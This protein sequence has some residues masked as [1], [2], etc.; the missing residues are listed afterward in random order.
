M[1]DFQITNAFLH[2]KS[3]VTESSLHETEPYSAMPIILSHESLWIDSE[4]IPN[5]IPPLMSNSGIDISNHGSFFDTTGSVVSSTIRNG[6]RVSAVKKKVRLELTRGNFD[7]YTSSVEDLRRVVH[8]NYATGYSVVVE[9]NSNGVLSILPS[10]LWEIQ[11][12]AG[13]VMIDKSVQSLI[14]QNIFITAYFYCGRVGID[15]SIK[16]TTTDDIEE[17]VTNKFFTRELLLSHITDLATDNTNNFVISVANSDSV[18]EGVCNKFFNQKNFDSAFHSKSLS[19]LNQSDD[20]RLVN[21]Q[22]MSNLNLSIGGVSEVGF[23]VNI[24]PPNDTNA[25]L[26][27]ERGTAGENILYFENQPI[28]ATEISSMPSIAPQEHDSLGNFTGCFEGPTRGVHTGDVKGNVQGFVSDLSN[29]PIIEAKILGDGEGH[30]VGTVNG[31]LVGKFEGHAKIVTGSI[32]NASHVTIG[33]FDSTASFHVK[34][35]DTHVQIAHTDGS[36]ALIECHAESRLAVSCSVLETNSF[37]CE[38]MDCSQTL[39]VNDLNCNNIRCAGLTNSFYGIFETGRIEDVSEIVGVS[40]SLSLCSNDTTQT[41]Q[42]SCADSFATRSRGSE[43]IFDIISCNSCTFDDLKSNNISVS[44]FHVE[45]LSFDTSLF[46]NNPNIV[47]NTLS[48]S[49]ITSNSLSLGDVRLNNITV[50]GGALISNMFSDYI[51]TDSVTTQVLSLAELHY[52]E[53]FSIDINALSVQVLCVENGEANT[54]SVA[55]IFYN[56]SE[57]STT[58]TT[59]LESFTTNSNNIFSVSL[60]ASSIDC[61][62][63]ESIYMNVQS[64]SALH[65]QTFTLFSDYFNSSHSH[66]LQLSCSHAIAEQI[67]ISHL[68]SI[69]IISQNA[70]SQQLSTQTLFSN[71]IAAN[72]F[73]CH[74]ISV[75]YL[76]ID[77]SSALSI[78]SLFADIQELTSNHLSVNSSDIVS[79]NTETISVSNINSNRIK[80]SHLSTASL[81]TELSL[82]NNLS[83]SNSITALNINTPTIFT[84]QTISDIIVSRQLSVHN[85][86]S[87]I[88][89]LGLLSVSNATMKN[90]FSSI[91]SCSALNCDDVT[92]PRASFDILSVNSIVGVDITLSTG[93]VS[94]E[95]VESL[96]LSV[97]ESIDVAL[98]ALSL[99]D[100]DGLNSLSCAAGNIEMLTS[101]TILVNTQRGQNLSVSEIVVS[102]LSVS[103]LHGIV[104]T[105]ELSVTGLV[106][107]ISTSSVTASDLSCGTLFID[108]I[109]RSVPHV[110]DTT[111]PAVLTTSTVGDFALFAEDT[112][113]SGDMIIQG[114]LYVTDTIFM[115]TQPSL[116][117]QNVQ[118]MV[119]SSISVGELAVGMLTGIGGGTLG[120]TITDIVTNLLSVSPHDTVHEGNMQIEGNLVVSGVVLTGAHNKLMHNHGSFEMEGILSVSGDVISNGINIVE[121]LLSVQQKLDSLILQ[122]EN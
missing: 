3:F 61:S 21:S 54:L 89:V 106:G 31:D 15:K 35:S 30:W 65:C 43:C 73:E 1:T 4:L 121:T 116:N 91:L 13:V 48:V 19:D 95:F 102:S 118:K 58:K 113:H 28:G 92:A 101:D 66:I 37:I 2:R 88:S 46:L 38:N 60:S 81:F 25:K 112:K 49:E 26:Y 59:V 52:P 83:C 82:V 29:H 80:S 42:L 122:I 77:Q 86:Y 93:G 39:K 105:Q 67:S 20:A 6:Q 114:S 14:P 68:D 9:Y 96:F 119:A 24:I 78:A 22:T 70:I 16:D 32:D 47:F 84:D 63:I 57:S 85:A 33:T 87:D 36:S 110:S 71:T 100:I 69:N 55:N 117:I 5:Q 10:H 75:N 34:S 62:S 97:N 94:M 51:Q 115:G 120:G 45:N 44:S 27:V 99:Q 111:D 8:Q 79:L 11:Y 53:N 41:L 17:G 64:V 76:Q 18:T 56:S 90:T 98:N 108:Q 74:D 107:H 12:M 7:E 23:N 109:V 104:L 40:A 50:E 103:T 72:V